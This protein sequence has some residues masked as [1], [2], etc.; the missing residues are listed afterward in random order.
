MSG[1]TMQLYVNGK[2]MGE[3]S[4]VTYEISHDE[5]ADPGPILRGETCS[6]T[7]EC[8]VP[9]GA[10]DFLLPAEPA[11]ASHETLVKRMRYGGRKGRSARRRLLA[12]ALPIDLMTERLRY[13]GRA[14]FLDETEAL[15][16]IKSVG[17]R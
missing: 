6:V 10:L 9:V 11:G 15:V 14:T 17:F 13:R 7:G 1:P 5:Y 4:D 3:V 2:P 8:I 12:K 16:T